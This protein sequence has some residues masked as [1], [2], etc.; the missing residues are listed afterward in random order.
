MRILKKLRNDVIMVA[1]VCA[2]GYIAYQVLLDDQAK[3]GIK[4]LT[5]TVKESYSSLSGIVNSRIG[6]IMDEDVVLQNRADI[7]QAWADLGY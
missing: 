6:T 7:K 5:Q 1:V 4:D 3:Q 2:A